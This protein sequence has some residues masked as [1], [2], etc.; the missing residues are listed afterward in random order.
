M[1][2][3]N[4]MTPGAAIRQRFHYGRGYAAD[5]AAF[6]AR[7]RRVLYALFA[8]LLPFLLT[9]RMA[10]QAI[11]KGSSAAFAKASCWAL[12]LNVAWSAG[13]AAG[14][15]LGPDPRPRIF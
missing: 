11:A 13:E 4:T 3:H 10:R 12:M 8:P 15:V 7:P 14:Y 9:A 1:T 6:A 5:R 2:F